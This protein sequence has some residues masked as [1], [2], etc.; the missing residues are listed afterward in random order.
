ML[1]GLVAAPAWA[2]PRSED[3]AGTPTAAAASP[4]RPRVAIVAFAL[5]ASERAAA[6][7]S[8]QGER[9][10]R[11][12]GRHQLL[13]LAGLLDPEG[14]KAHQD[15]VES[16]RASLEKAR[17]LYDEL[18]PK[19]AREQCERAIEELERSDLSRSFDQLV[20]ASMLRIAAQIANAETGAAD[21]ALR[22][23]LPIDPSTPFDPNLFTPDFV[24]QTKSRRAELK[25][26]ATMGLD[27]ETSPVAAR[28]FVDGRFRGI[29]SVELR[30]LTPGEHVLTLVAPGYQLLQKQVRPG[31]GGTRVETLKPASGLALYR[32]LVQKL[33]ADFRG[34]GRNLAAREFAQQVGADQLLV[35]GVQAK[36]SDQL[37]ALGVRVDARDGH[38]L[39]Y[40]EEPLPNDEQRF[41]KPAEEFLHKLLANDRPRGEDGEPIATTGGGFE[42][43]ARHTGYL[44]LGVA[45]LAIG[46]GVYFGR[47]AGDFESQYLASQKPQVDPSYD[48]LASDGR[49]AALFADLSYLTAI[50]AGGTGLFLAITGRGVGGDGDAIQIEE[51]KRVSR[52]PRVEDEASPAA[53][54]AKRSKPSRSDD[55]DDLGGW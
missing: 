40:L 39:A 42:W 6:K 22:E 49:R 11:E 2:A 55:E 12:L 47:S 8:Y 36:D 44:L 54:P 30:N 1:I 27:L 38:E 34:E 52:S 26:E 18:E 53:T 14:L 33:S 50:V 13:D 3:S 10:A 5:D 19:K 31:V 16:A 46:S 25:N 35:V 20:S 21:A 37:L 32:E 23:L 28:V 4:A 41:G 15:R 24:A 17:Q 29:S 43:R 9:I 48:Q 45:A 51:R 7:L